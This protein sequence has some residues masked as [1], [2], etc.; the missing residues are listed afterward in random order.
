[1]VFSQLHSA[2]GTTA[3]EC[4]RILKRAGFVS[5]ESRE[6]VRET[7]FNF[8]CKGGLESGGS[9]GQW[10]SLITSLTKEATSV[11]ADISGNTESFLAFQLSPFT[12]GS[13]LF[14]LTFEILQ[15]LLAVWLSYK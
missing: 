3:T 12:A 2:L 14:H 11:L 9:E 15:P 13:L 10:Y 1:M 4:R 5:K 6:L 8:M 7:S